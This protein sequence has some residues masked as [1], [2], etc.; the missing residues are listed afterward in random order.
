M[1][2]RTKSTVKMLCAR[3]GIANEKIPEEAQR[4]LD[5]CNDPN[6]AQEQKAI[7]KDELDRLIQ[8]IEDRVT[9]R[10]LKELNGG[11]AAH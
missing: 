9:T 11:A 10:R 5:L 7:A 4:L 3:S 8:A 6:V 2:T 1:T